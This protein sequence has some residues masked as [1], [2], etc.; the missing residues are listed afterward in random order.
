MFA[1]PV[2][3]RIFEPKHDVRALEHMASG[4][5]PIGSE[6]ASA[7]LRHR[8]AAAV[9][10][11][12]G[13]PR[14]SYRYLPGLPRGPLADPGHDASDTRCRSGAACR[15]QDAICRFNSRPG[16]AYSAKP[17]WC[18]SGVHTTFAPLRESPGLSRST[19]GSGWDRM[20]HSRTSAIP[21]E[22][23]LQQDPP[24]GWAVRRLSTGH[25]GTIPSSK[26]VQGTGTVAE[27]CALDSAVTSPMAIPW[28]SR[29]RS[30]TRSV[31]LR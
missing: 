17:S 21:H 11:R 28:F 6:S 24:Y 31:I 1:T 14:S 9:R 10:F 27:A 12:P 29:I 4:C 7:P 25:A 13:A 19:T 3:P 5:G 16:R 22:R 8:Q 2:P 15:R 30:R 23:W 20:D 18:L 26:G